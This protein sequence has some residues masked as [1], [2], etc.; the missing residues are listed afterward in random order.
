LVRDEEKSFPQ[1]NTL[2]LRSVNMKVHGLY[3]IGFLLLFCGTVLSQ[4]S[5]MEYL[6]PNG[7]PDAK[8]DGPGDKPTLTF[9]FPDKPNGAAIV[10]CPGG[11]YRGLAPHEAD[12]IGNWCNTF[13]VTGIVLRY[14]HALSGAGYHHPTP[15]LDAQHALSLVRSRAKELGI[16]PGKIGIMGFS[17]GGHLAASLG[18]HF[19]EK[20]RS[21]LD[22]LKSISCRPDFMILV[23]PVITMDTAFTHLGSRESLLG[24]NPPKDLVELMSNEKQVTPDCPPGF[25]VHTTDDQA[26]PVE[27]AVAMYA[28]LQKSKVPAEMHIFQHGAHGFGLGFNSGAVGAWPGLCKTWMKNLGLIP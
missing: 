18:T 25:I 5:K 11:A 13:G 28:A 4:K 19:K 23:Y 22:P 17:A 15:L 7:A 9:F 21:S 8:G 24:L 20:D 2:N 12:T 3:L 6:W 26:V 16:D 27:N 10:I 1:N 14:R